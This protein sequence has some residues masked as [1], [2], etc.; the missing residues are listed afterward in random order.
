MVDNCKGE[1]GMSIL[2]IDLGTTNAKA[3]LVEEDT[4]AVIS[5]GARSEERRVG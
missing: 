5:S 2:S 3:V 4:G 1:V